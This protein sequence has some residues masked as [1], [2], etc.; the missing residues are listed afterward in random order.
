MIE[1][2]VEATTFSNQVLGQAIQEAAR[3]LSGGSNS[4]L[5]YQIGKHVSILASHVEML[6]QIFHISLKVS[7]I[8]M[9]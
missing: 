6:T 7:Y 4:L 1:H 2:D 9:L 3:S 5:R 8:L